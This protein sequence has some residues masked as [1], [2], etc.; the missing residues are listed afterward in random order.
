MDAAAP[1]PAS[2][3]PGRARGQVM[4]E[5]LGV[6]EQFLDVQREVLEQF[7]ARP[8][9]AGARAPLAPAAPL[10]P[11]EVPAAAPAP[12]VIPK[13]GPLVGEVTH[14]EAGREVVVRR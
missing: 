13:G 1:A 9:R 4:A 5:Y 10:P 7:L 8:R 14:Y 2:G 6:M 11:P 3:R 12:D